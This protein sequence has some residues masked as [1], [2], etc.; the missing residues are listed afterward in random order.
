MPLSS[1]E[2]SRLY[3]RIALQL[4]ALIVAGEYAAG[5]RLPPER[6]LA[7]QMGVSR[8][9][10]R[11]A[12][13]AL[14]VEGYVEIRIGAGIYARKPDTG[15]INV[16]PALTHEEGPLELIRARA[17]LEPEIA[18]AAAHHMTRA[19]LDGISKA[20][21]LME[22]EAAAGHIPTAGDRQFHVRIAEASGNGV[23]VSLVGQLFDGRS[24][25]LFTKLALYFENPKSWAAAISEHRSVLAALAARD[26]DAA[27]DAMRH[28][29]QM[30]HK[31]FNAGWP[32]AQRKTGNGL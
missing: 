13:I 9:S 10:V 3:R 15:T 1:I 32:K 19:Q 2:P 31:R 18:A 22:E 20:I 11:E 12:L 14:E 16:G 6:D 23:L 30:S 25:P 21:A 26:S 29:M 5:T 8:P 24:N 7:M 27:R 28:H 17:V 4:R